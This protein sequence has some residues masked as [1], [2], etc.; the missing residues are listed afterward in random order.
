MDTARYRAFL[1]AAETGSIKNAAD[2]MGYTSSAVSQLIQALE[3]ELGVTLLH[4]GKKG[5]MLTIE[6]EQLIQPVR[7]LM[8]KE[9]QIYQIAGDIRGTI[10]GTINIAA[11]HSIVRAWMPEIVSGFQKLYPQVRINLYEGT[12]VDIIERLKSGKAHIAVFNDSAMSESHDWIPLAEDP[13]MAVLP[14]GHPMAEKKKFP[15]EKFE[16][17]RFLMPEHGWDFDVL[18][19]LSKAKVTP[20]VYLSTFDSAIILEMV[21]KGLGV[22]IVNGM[23]IPGN[24][25]NVRVMPL[26]PPSSIEM[27]IAVMSFKRATP[28]VKKFVEFMQEKILSMQAK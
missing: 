10:Y 12:Q 14:E 13:M 19:V 28:A 24:E 21:A 2:I 5:V 23:S 9:N 27:G 17:E 22:S 6:G 1:T 25:K 11:Y 18:E 15:V 26:D 20:D 8:L 16:G 4:R 3:K 7:E